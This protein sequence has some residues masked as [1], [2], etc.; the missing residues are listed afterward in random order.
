[1]TAIYTVNTAR[2]C[3]ELH[4]PQKPSQETVA[5]VKAAGFR[6][7][8]KGAL[9]Y[10][11]QRAETLAFVRSIAQEG[12]P[13]EVCANVSKAG[14][15]AG[16]PS[17]VTPDGFRFVFN[18]YRT[19]AGELVKGSY[20]FADP[21]AD[22]ACI[23]SVC[24]YLDCYNH[25]DHPEGTE[26][27][28][29]SDSMTD[30]FEHT[31]LEIPVESP[32]YPAALEGMRRSEEHE[33]ARMEKLETRRNGG[34]PETPEQKQEKAILRRVRLF[35]ETH[36][37]AAESVRKEQK[38]EQAR[39]AAR[40]ET[41]NACHRLS[42]AY[43]C[44]ET[45]E[46]KSK[47]LGEI[48]QYKADHAAAL[49]RKQAETF[50]GVQQARIDRLRKETPENVWEESGLV[51][52][53]EEC[54]GYSLTDWKRVTSY[55]WIIYD[56]ET[57]RQLYV[58]HCNTREEAEALFHRAVH[59]RQRQAQGA[60][61]T[62]GQQAAAQLSAILQSM[63]NMEA[64]ASTEKADEKAKVCA[65]AAPLPL[66][67][68]FF[69]SKADSIQDAAESLARRD[70]TAPFAAGE[71][72][73]V[74]HAVTLEPDALSYFT[75]NLLEN[76]AFLEDKGGTRIESDAVN[77]WEDFVRLSPE[78]RAKLPRYALCV[79]V[80]DASGAPLLLVNP[81][82]YG[83]P[84]Y[85]A[86]LPEDFPFDAFRESLARTAPGTPNTSPC[87]RKK[88]PAHAPAY[89]AQHAPASQIQPEIPVSSF[90]LQPASCGAPSHALR[91]LLHISSGTLAVI[92]KEKGFA[93]DASYAALDD[94]HS[95]LIFAASSL[96]QDRFDSWQSLL[97]AA[98]PIAFP[99]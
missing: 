54:G 96:P 61:A 11:K 69:A 84:R 72:A 67:H 27:T 57:L 28:N 50:R 45:P 3:I 24:L 77:T 22:P 46:V 43:L 9:W 38:T 30:Y 48:Q 25:P 76:Y 93:G 16:N 62:P 56:A 36:K 91:D 1:M 87:T 41:I 18:G 97:E 92:A 42:Q 44:A 10:A 4:F 82:G 75:Q 34:T 99:A 89:P 23:F 65:F 20:S 5:A 37:Q 59:Q 52:T 55:R 73:L 33:A 17:N 64:C 60:P 63:Q 49:A 26:T 6:W 8:R 40:Q 31:K 51:S 35:G 86:F 83:Y 85:T 12:E 90:V 53:V 14:A 80:C 19:P 2:Q 21:C 71:S 7:S 78:D 95:R 66:D 58:K 88:A 39:K 29:N 94:I 47:V 15:K 70:Q 68:V 81:Q 13:A 74:T 32:A 79:V 98:W